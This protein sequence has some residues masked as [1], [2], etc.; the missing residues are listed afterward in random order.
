M[1]TL[2][3]TA[4]YS[5]LGIK[6]GAIGLVIFIILRILFFIALDA[7]RSAFPRTLKPDNRFGVLTK[8]AFPQTAS[9]S[10]QLTFKLQTISGDV[11]VASSAARIYFMPKNRP[12]LLSL[13]R[14]QSFVSRLGFTSSPNQIA[15]TSYRWIDL[16]SPLRTIEVDIVSNHFTLNY[17]FAQD[18]TLFAE[19]QIPTPQQI[20]KEAQDFL[21]QSNLKNTDLNPQP[22]ISYLKLVGDQL[23]P[24]TSQSVADAVKV[25]YFRKDI[26]GTQVVTDHTGDGIITFIFSGSR[27]ADR[28]LLRVK[29]RYWPVDYNTQGV[30]KLKTTEVAYR[31][32]QA[33]AAYYAALPSNQTQIPITNVRLGYYDGSASQL[34]LQPVFIFEGEKNF[35]SY[36]PAVAPPWTE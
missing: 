2:T 31:E 5:R 4:Y 25:D 16:K 13:S 6:W 10:A 29:Y 30:Y 33:G 22:Q 23:E 20:Q 36:V 35:V 19:R 24:T 12:N 32:L 9:P 7:I 3:E 28:R 17:A 26:E 15:D 21:Q 11:P 18:L 1:A 14:A 8:I 34:Y 27:R